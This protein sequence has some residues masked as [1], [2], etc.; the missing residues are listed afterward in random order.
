M[1]GFLKNV[2]TTLFGSSADRRFKQ[3]KSLYDNFIAMCSLSIFKGPSKDTEEL[4]N[5]LKTCKLNSLAKDSLTT[6][7]RQQDIDKLQAVRDK[8][9]VWLE[10]RNK[11]DRKDAMIRFSNSVERLQENLVRKNNEV[12]GRLIPVN[13]EVFIPSFKKPNKQQKSLYDVLQ[14]K[15]SAPVFKSTETEQLLN[16]LKK[17]KLHSDNKD[18]YSLTHQ[19]RL[20]DIALLELVRITLHNYQGQQY[21]NRWHDAISRF[22]QFDIQ[23]TQSFL[24]DLDT[25]DILSRPKNGNY[26]P[27]YTDPRCRA[28]E[29]KKFLPLD[30]EQRFDEQWNLYCK[31]NNKVPYL[32]FR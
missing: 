20:Q 24:I 31:K 29:L 12:R 6:N 26:T 3:H 28:Q 32:Q 8:I 9:S 4:I 11:S 21:A 18:R 15:C 17:C 22:L 27:T 25:R 10:S 14:E 19:E 13:E 1:S 23:G 7:E 2:K 5:F 16:L 30:L